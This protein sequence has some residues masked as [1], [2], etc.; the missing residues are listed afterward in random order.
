MTNFI[1]AYIILCL[2]SP[3]LLRVMAALA[4]KQIGNLI[5]CKFP[6]LHNLI[7]IFSIKPAASQEQ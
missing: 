2:N 3:S 6:S 1:C 4:R 5:P 7:D